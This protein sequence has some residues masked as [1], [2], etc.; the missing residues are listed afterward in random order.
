MG[1]LCNSP[2]CLGSELPD[3]Q[4]LNPSGAFVHIRTTPPSPQ[5]V[6]TSLVIM[7]SSVGRG[8]KPPPIEALGAVPY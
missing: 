8:I 4:A 6:S 5:A 2:F 3:N 7:A 1:T